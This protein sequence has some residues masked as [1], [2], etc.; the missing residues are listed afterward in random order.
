MIASFNGPKHANE[1]CFKDEY[2]VAGID[3]NVKY[4]FCTISDGKHLTMTRHMSS[5]FAKS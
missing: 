4:N 5:S 2:N 1:L 3:L